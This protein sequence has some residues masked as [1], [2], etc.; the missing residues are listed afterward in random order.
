LTGRSV[1]DTI[2]L[3][4]YRQLHSPILT[5]APLER[6]MP[7]PAEFGNLLVASCLEPCSA[8]DGANA[9]PLFRHPSRYEVETKREFMR[10]GLARLRPLWPRGLPVGAAF[11]GVAEAEEDLRLLHRNGLIELRIIEPA[12]FGVD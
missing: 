3:L 10:A 11:G 4:C 12:D 5:P 2:D 1:E 8:S 7:S 6:V 9:N